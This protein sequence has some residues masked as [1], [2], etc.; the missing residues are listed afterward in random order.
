MAYAGA[1]L[2]IAGTVVSALG[3]YQAGKAQEAAYK[4]NAAA[5]LAASQA[6]ASQVEQETKRRLGAAN[7]AFAAGGVTP[8]GSPTAVASDLATQGELAKQL[9]LYRGQTAANEQTFYARQASR[10]ATIG[11]F[12]TLLSGTGGAL[13]GMPAGGGAGSYSTPNAAGYGTSPGGGTTYSG[14]SYSYPTVGSY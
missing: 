12:S 6:Q 3:Q 11:A 2:A 9:T 13:M 14:S 5:D 10:A 7:A 1:A 8:E 4:Y